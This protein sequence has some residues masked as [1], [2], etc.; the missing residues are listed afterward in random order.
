MS[1]PSEPPE[2]RFTLN[3]HTGE[4]RPAGAP[5][6]QDDEEEWIELGGIDRGTGHATVDYSKASG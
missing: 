1:T 4:I 6:R 5:E 2:R 3:L